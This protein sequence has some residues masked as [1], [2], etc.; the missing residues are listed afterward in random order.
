M[1]IL[2]EDLDKTK[3]PLRIIEPYYKNI[4]KVGKGAFGIVYKA[5]ELN[6]GR[7]VAIKQISINKNKDR[8]ELFKEID[9]LK[10][11]HHTNIVEY[12]NYYKDE[13]NIYIVM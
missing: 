2:S 3:F 5:F 13:D 8:N 6:S 9:L 12:Y 4:E 7:N 11:I 1:E 10:N